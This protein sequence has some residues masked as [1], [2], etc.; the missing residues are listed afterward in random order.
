[1]ADF[2]APAVQNRPEF[3][4]LVRLVFV[5]WKLACEFVTIEAPQMDLPFSIG[6]PI[7]DNGDLS[8]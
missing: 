2:S 6:L 3:G 7:S 5:S 4:G 1:V 8:F